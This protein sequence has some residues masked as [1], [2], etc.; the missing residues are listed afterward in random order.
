VFPLLPRRKEPLIEGWPD[1]ATTDEAQLNRWFDERPD[2]NYAILANEDVCFI[3]TDPRN[4]AVETLARLE[5]EEPEFASLLKTRTVETGR[6]DGGRHFYFRP[7]KGWK[8]RQGKDA[9]GPGVDVMFWHKYVVGP[10]SIH[11]ET[12]QTYRVLNPETEI[13]PLPSWVILRLLEGWEEARGEGVLSTLSGT[14]D[15]PLPPTSLDGQTVS[16]LREKVRGYLTDGLLSEESFRGLYQDREVQVAMTLFVG[17]PRKAAEQAYTRSRGI[18]DRCLCP[19]PGHDEERPSADVV[20]YKRH[21]VLKVRCHHGNHKPTGLPDIYAMRTTGVYRDLTKAELK[22]W[23]LRMLVDMGVPDPAEVE[24]R[25][26]PDELP[27]DAP[28]GVRA[29][30]HAI[31]EVLSLRYL[32]G[33]APA[34]LVRGF[35]SWW[36]GLS[37]RQV[38]Q[39]LQW[40]LKHWFLKG[41]VFLRKDGTFSETRETKMSSECFVMRLF[42]PNARKSGDGVKRTRKEWA[43][44]RQEQRELEALSWWDYEE[45][46]QSGELAE[47]MERDDELFD[48]DWNLREPYATRMAE[49]EREGVS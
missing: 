22:L 26:L 41:G 11:P 44:Y 5:A 43:I 19:R 3:D 37:E 20:F 21:R 7:P 48:E 25:A 15:A 23:T 47:A 1:R 17:V 16:Q 32:F 6:R 33:V 35:L 31:V 9:L 49:L 12:G 27:D 40:L 39:C 28:D 24:R 42:V 18:S 8:L 4:G 46:Y 2:A 14:R 10:G 45:A 30:Y 36:S 34:P 29:V 38:G 13:V